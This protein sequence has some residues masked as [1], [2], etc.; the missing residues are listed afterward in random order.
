MNMKNKAIILGGLFIFLLFSSAQ[1]DESI[2]NAQYEDSV[3]SK[4]DAY[5][6]REMKR[7]HLPGLAAG[8]VKDDRILYLKG[9]G[10]ADSSGRPVTPDTPFGLGS[11]SKSITAM[12]VL[13]LA[14]IGKIDLDAPIQSYI[15]TKFN[16]A[17]SITV[18][19]LLN[20]TSGFSQISTSCTNMAYCYDLSARCHSV[21]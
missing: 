10:H 2:Q 11:I 19:Q 14:E 5:I 9:Y 8:I 12:A 17:E 7:Q 21:G 3:F 4:V 20:Q 13:Q 15:S 18:R 6:A 16:G 1:A